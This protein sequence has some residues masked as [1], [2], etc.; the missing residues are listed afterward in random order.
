MLLPSFD[1]WWDQTGQYYDPDTDDVPWF[2]KRKEL[3]AKA[4][5]DAIAMSGNYIA[6]HELFPQKITFA[7]GRVV[8]M[9]GQGHLFVGA[10]DTRR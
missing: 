1:V 3:A 6:D 8:K 2:D 5:A 4:F 9:K 10:I 7:N